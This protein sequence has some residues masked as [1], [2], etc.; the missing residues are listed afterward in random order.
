MARLSAG[1][2][3]YRR[4]GDGGI[5]VLLGHMGGPYWQRKDERAWSIPKG[6]CNAGEDPLAAAR[7][8][9]EEEIGR[10]PPDGPAFELGDVVQS[11][12]KVVR[13]WA[14]EGDVDVSEITSGTFEME[15]PPRSGRMQ[16]FP[17]FDRAEWLGLE[18]ARP[19]LVKAQAGLL[20]AL[21][22]RLD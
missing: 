4:R 1:L 18:A 14:L 13:A 6:Q 2:L 11:G 21:A 16:S 12:G 3:L 22:E 17:E 20:D 7:R 9:F 19:K 10:P 15:W 5:E 8:E